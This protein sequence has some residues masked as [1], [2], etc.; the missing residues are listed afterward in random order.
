MHYRCQRVILKLTRSMMISDTTEFRNQQITQP[1]VTPDDRILHG[2]KQLTVALQGAPSSRSGDQI[3]VIQSLQ[4]T[5]NY[6]AI[7]TTHTEMTPPQPSEKDKWYYR[8]PPRVHPPVPRV[9]NPANIERPQAPRVLVPRPAMPAQ[10]VAHRTHARHKL[11][12]PAAPPKVP[13]MEPPDVPEQP[14]AH[15]T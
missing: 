4:D 12:P 10:P 5:L 2:L 11:Y 3:R 13:P 7:D 14:V 9:K 8:L 1:L 15:C 6:W